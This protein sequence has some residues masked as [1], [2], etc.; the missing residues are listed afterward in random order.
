MTFQVAVRGELKPAADTHRTAVARHPRYCDCSNAVVLAQRPADAES[1][2]RSLR[3]RP[4]APTSLNAYLSG[5][6]EDGSQQLASA[7]TAV[8]TE[9]RT[10]VLQCLLGT[11]FATT[12]GSRH[13]GLG[14]F[15]LTSAPANAA[16]S[17]SN[18]RHAAL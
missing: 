9:R 13:P 18:R 12:A 7:P 17:S 11:K 8:C 1:P 15:G 16:R 3:S 14:L 5:G 2:P 6:G 4:P 10:E